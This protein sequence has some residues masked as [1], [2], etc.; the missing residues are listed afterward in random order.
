[1]FDK[2]MEWGTKVIVISICVYLFIMLSVV[3]GFVM[4][5]ILYDNQI[6]NRPEYEHRYERE[7]IDEVIVV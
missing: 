4:S 6:S 7:Q 1:M 2:N 5:F 3:V